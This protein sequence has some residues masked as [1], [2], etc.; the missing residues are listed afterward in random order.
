MSRLRATTFLVG[1]GGL[2]LAGH[3]ALANPQGGVVVGGQATITTSAPNTVTV[4]QSTKIVIVD[5]NSFD[6]GK[7]ETTRFNQPNASSTAVNRIGGN[8]PSVILGNLSANGQVILINGNG[9]L[10]GPGA[11]INVGSLIAT[12]HDASNADLM[13]GKANFDGP[14]S[15]T[16]SITNN[17]RINASSGIVGLIAPAVT[18]NGI[19]QAR[20]GS[21]TLG[22]ASKFTLDFTGDGL[23]SFPVDAEVLSRALDASG[24]PVKA[25]VVNRGRIEGSTVLLTAR[26]AKDIVENVISMGGLVRATAAH[27]SGGSIVLDGGDGGVS[28]SGTLNASNAAP[29]AVGGTVKVL[30]NSVTLTSSAKLAA[31]GDA[32]GGTILVGGNA[33]GAGP[34]RNATTTTVAAGAKL[35]ADAITSGN[36]GTVV[37]WS[38]KTTSFAGAISARGGA[39]GGNGG[40]VETSGKQK[41]TVAHG[42][43]VNTLAPKGKAG[44]WL[45]DPAVITITLPEGVG[46]TLAQGSSTTDTTSSITID[47]STIDA[48]SSNVILA[49]ST[50]I[51]VNMAISM[52]NSGVGILFEGAGS[53]PTAGPSSG[54][55]LTANITTLNGGVTI[56][57][58]TTLGS[59]VTISAGTSTVTFNGAVNGAHILS[60]GNSGGVTFGG[61]VGGTTSLARLT[62]GTGTTTIDGNITTT[63]VITINGPTTLGSDVTISAGTGAVTF[64][65]AVNGAHNLIISNSGGVTFDSTVGANTALSSLATGTGT[66]T[67]D[68]N[69]TTANGNVTVNGGTTLGANVT[70]TAGTGA[71]DFAKTVNGAH[72]LTINN[73]GG[74][75]FGGVVGGST[76]LTGLTTGTGTTTIDGNITTTNGAITIKGPTIIGN[77]TTGFTLSTG[78]GAVDFKGTVDGAS[79]GTSF[80]L[81]T[82][83]TGGTTFESM[84]GATTPLT[85]LTTG[86]GT[87]TLDGNV[88]TTNG[89]V[90]IGGALTLGS[91][92]TISAGTGVV[93]FTKTVNGAYN[94]IINNS[95]GVTFGGVVGGSTGLTGLT[96]SAG[97]TTI[98]G[99]IT[100]TNGA[101]TIGGA[102]TLGGAVAISAGT[103]AVTF[104]GAVEGARALV[105]TNSG[106]VAFDSTVGANTALASLTTGTGTTTLDGNVSTTNGAIKILGAATLGGDITISAGTGA[107]TFTG[108]V[109]GAHNLTIT[110]SGAVTFDSTLGANTALAGL[111][112]GTGTTTFDGN[113]TTTNGN[114]TVNGATT[115]GGVVTISAGTGAVDFAGAVSSAA[116]L[117]ISNSGGVT[118]GA[119]TLGGD[120]TINAGTG[121]VNFAGTVD[122]A[123]NLII[124]NSAGVTFGGAIGTVTGLASLTTGTGTTTLDG[125]VGGSGAIIFNGPVTLG[126]DVLI[127]GGFTNNVTFTGPVNGA[128]NLSFTNL[129]A[130]TFDST[131][132]AATP[133]TSLT[134]GTSVSPTFDGNVTLAGNST[135]GVGLSIAT[136]TTLGGDVTVVGGSGN[137][138]F[139]G[140][141][142][143]G[144]HALDVTTTSVVTFGNTLSGL[145]SLTTT[146]ST[147]INSNITTTNGGV[148]IG[149][150]TTLGGNFTISAGTGAVDFKGTV[151]GAHKLTISDS[152][153]TTFES[154]VGATTPLTS[155][156]TGTGLTTLDGNISTTNGSVTLGGATTLG[157]SVTISA[158]TG[159]VTFTG[160]VSGAHALTI[161][162]SGST[163]FSAG[164]SGLTGLTT[165]SGTTTVSG[166][167]S[168]SGPTMLHGNLTITAG[169]SAVDFAGTV[170]GAHVLSITD[171]GGVTFESTVGATTPLTGLSTGTGTT[172]L[173]GNVTTTNGNVTI[174]GLTTLG[175]DITISAGTGAVTFNGAVDGAHNLAISNSGAVTFDSTVGANTALASLTTGTGT[176]TFDGNVTTANG[177]IAVNGATTLGGNVTINTGSGAVTFTGAVSGAHA[178]TISNSG[179]TA[180]NAGFSGLT[181]LTTG[182]GTTTVSGAAS[183]S[184]PTLLGG[185]LTITAG[186]SAVNFAGTVDGAY[187]LTISGSGSVTFGGVVG[188]GTALA[189]LT[190]G[191]GIAQLNGNITTTGVQNYDGPVQLLGPLIMEAGASNV[192]FASTLQSSATPVD[193]NSL[194]V[195]TSG[196]ATFNGVVG[197]G[198]ELLRTGTGPTFINANITTAS[199]QYYQG[200]VTLDA[201]SLSSTDA[202]G[203][204]K[205]G[206]ATTLGDDV[207]IS[208]GSGAV[209]FTGAVDGAYKLTITNS[210]GV[211]FDGTVGANT[212]LASL[213]TGTGTT[214]LDGNVSTTNGNVTIG[215]GTTLGA[216]VTINAGTGTISFN[217]AVDGAHKLVLTTSGTMLFDGVVGG[218][219]A[220]ASLTTGTG[221][222]QLNGNITT[223]GIQSYDGPVQLLGPLIMEAGAANVTFASTLQSSATPVDYN[224][225]T[226][227]TSGSATFN[228]VVDLGGNLYRTGTGPTFI[229]ANITTASAQSYQGAVTLNASSLSSTDSTGSI[230][231][232]GETTLAHDATVTAVGAAILTGVD[233]HYNLTV[234]SDL[235]VLFP[236]AVGATTPL[237]S[238]TTGGATGLYGNVT[239]TGAQSYGARVVLRGNV[240]IQTTDALV[241]FASTIDS[242][243][244]TA[245]NFSVTTGAG[246]QTYGGALGSTHALG[247]VTL[248]SSNTAA[249]SLPAITANGPV[250]IATGGP[251]TLAGINAAGDILASTQTGDLTV[252]GSVTTTSTTAT[253]LTLEAGIS[254]DRVVSPG[255][256]DTNGNVVIAGGSLSIGTGGFG[257]IYTGSI[258]GS[259][260]LSNVVGA[261]NFR[262]WSDTNG[263]TGYTT[264]LGAGISA[265]YREQPVV[266]VS[267]TALGSGR[268]YDGTTTAAT[269]SLTGLVN[270]AVGSAS[271]TISVTN[272]SGAPAVLLNAGSYTLRV[273]NASASGGLAGLGYAVQTGASSYV[274]VPATL[275]ITGVQAA[276]R[277]YDG[278]TAATLSNVGS[279]T[280]L[281]GAE[282]LTLTPGAAAFADPNAGA[283]KTVTVTGYTISDGT[284]LASNYVLGSTTATTTATITPAILTAGLTGTVAKTYDGT[285]VANL[286]PANYILSGTIFGKDVVTLND[287]ATGAYADANAGTGKTVSVSGLAL[288][289]ANYVLSSTTAT[290][291]A[292][293]TPAILTAGLT[294]TVAKTYD[295]TTVA[296]LTPANYA[297]GGTIFGKD[298]VTLNDPATGAYADA[299]TGAGKTVS[300]SGLALDN[301][302]YALAATTISAGIGVINPA[303]TTVVT[304]LPPS[305]ATTGLTS[306]SSATS[307]SVIVADL[308]IP[309]DS[310]RT[311]AITVPVNLV[312]AF[313]VDTGNLIESPPPDVGVSAPDASSS[314]VSAP[315]TQ[316]SPQQDDKDTQ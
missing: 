33:H 112:T 57:G 259:T 178:L 124:N 95:G 268:T 64:N 291:T 83:N 202:S 222:T 26:A 156:T 43:T 316:S 150:A 264:P 255:M 228:G 177:S 246:A 75:T 55:T 166:G 272:G 315:G 164:F 9:L 157:G 32:G 73:S 146:G 91:N 158:G 76:G 223:T 97:T 238:L 173:D 241:S 125:N 206:G 153:G 237:A 133:L 134:L 25:L 308:T 7:G 131:V 219:T 144:G 244:A 288:D 54:T 77:N 21:V 243:N 108:A 289:N 52:A 230:E 147:T 39:D 248:S 99:N 175:S 143:G 159:A 198:G 281:V 297:L 311:E 213:A 6:I 74:V 109:E 88:T 181:G 279:L 261:G 106:G 313:Y 84:V 80:L 28:V 14:G 251:L 163:A 107:V 65:G 60:I 27:Q 309:A 284:G 139:S 161:S 51:A 233:G 29:G 314:A 72:T 184:G 282:T 81:T 47:P 86:A 37:I 41:L 231:V 269:L 22:A 292:T 11:K 69:V 187:G 79:S 40:F 121:A 172:T 294:G 190:T 312:G 192:T 138:T 204:I 165:G 185:N 36:G 170:D 63:G 293:I 200:A 265:I 310:F 115:L 13:S 295:G 197:L 87:A 18:N 34:E 212:A 183:V 154:T 59:D 252:G 122:G 217:G 123:Y 229:N 104:T 160:A 94:L 235:S 225:L 247:S 201:S 141:V 305:A 188:G 278:T 179:S 199:A 110:N 262:Y 234:D 189:S 20:L 136:A 89:N 258:T 191:T 169:T 31:S 232:D 50:S 17:G 207:T 67:F 218:G 61:V 196:A 42:A 116:A 203:S 240:A 148:T 5:W 129:G 249:L 271:G 70:I 93:D 66:T 145:T 46:D 113:V 205:V 98:D 226:V 105:I 151:N 266:T 58:P 306:T 149:G 254:A 180:F 56:D 85:R 82:T 4:D 267:A 100:T 256:A 220:L 224:S 276:D 285:T 44:D 186:T 221:T 78:T 250:T 23:I 12:T 307:D 214:T 127:N 53:T 168:V 283:G 15:S 215:G 10:F 182:S 62:T 286:T 119:T 101:V 8:D 303:G 263:N 167:A 162:N 274:I 16:A 103:G 126:A 114:I 140:G 171:T 111:T 174:G 48:A 209:I 211:T 210:G 35:K 71:V 128:Y 242:S 216:D 298:V 155:L 257:T 135:T 142:T 245:R 195:D 68:G 1:T 24:K 300:V 38:D 253:A 302:N 275:T 49:A 193:Y 239:T 304:A 120:A 299:N 277:S 117:I 280:G 118:F 137:V 132:G 2:L 290:I 227:D 130:V 270:G 176:T 90:T 3:P 194:T 102:T 260:G 45:L 92:V 19:I 96:T 30:G 236:G 296:S 208:A 152:G 301:A 287:P 273:T